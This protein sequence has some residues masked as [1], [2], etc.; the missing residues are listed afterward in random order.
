MVNTNKK[1]TEGVPYHGL[2]GVSYR[3][4]SHHGLYATQGGIWQCLLVIPK[5]M[6]ITPKDYTSKRVLA[7]N[8][9]LI[10]I[11]AD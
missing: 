10:H 7:L 9:H 3:P 6:N 4:Q 2:V 5:F 1:V 8:P 11:H